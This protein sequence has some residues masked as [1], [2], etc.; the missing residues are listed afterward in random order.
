MIHTHTHTHHCVAPHTVFARQALEALDLLLAFITLLGV[1]VSAHP[2]VRWNLRRRRRVSA[3]AREP[4][5]TSSDLSPAALNAPRCLSWTSR[6][7]VCREPGSCW[8]SV[9]ARCTCSLHTRHPAVRARFNHLNVS[10]GLKWSL[11]LGGKW[12]PLLEHP[13]THRCSTALA[14]SG[15]AAGSGTRCSKRAC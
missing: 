3:S 9:R 13:G 5:H 6:T 12:R 15:P 14:S 2:V 10:L 4:S 11:L 8:H 7:S 1:A